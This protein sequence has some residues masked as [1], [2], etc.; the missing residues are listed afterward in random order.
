ML[1]CA[2]VTLSTLVILVPTLVSAADLDSGLAAYDRQ[3]FVEA[4]SVLQEYAD[5][6]NAR[7]QF[8]IG[9]MLA[10]GRGGD[11]DVPAGL[12]WL[13]S[14]AQNGFPL[15]REQAPRWLENMARLTGSERARAEAVIAA[16]GSEAV[17]TR[18]LPLL[19]AHGC[20]GYH[21][22][23]AAKVMSPSYPHSGQREVR[24]ASVLVRFIVGVD[25][26]P[27]APRI[28]ASFPEHA[29]FEEAAI[30]ALLSSRFWPAELGNT[31]VEAEADTKFLFDVIG[32]G[33]LWN[34][35]ALKTLQKEADAGV[36]SAQYL[37]ST[38]V[39]SDQRALGISREQALAYLG[40]A[41]QSG[42]VRAAAW[43]AE[44]LATAP[45]CPYAES[46]TQWAARAA[47]G[48]IPLAQVRYARLLLQG[49]PSPDS[50]AQARNYLVA[51]AEST[52]EFAAVHAI[53]MLAT[54][55]FDIMRDTDSLKSARKRL[56]I[57]TQ[58]EDPQAWE[59]L[60]AADADLGD[61][62]EAVANEEKAL[63]LAQQFL[64]KTTS[65]T[66]RLGSYRRR[67]AWRGDLFRLPPAESPVP[68]PAKVHICD[69]HSTG[70]SCIHEFQKPNWA[71]IEKQPGS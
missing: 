24:N 9:A 52:S 49:T 55:P 25:G 32:G 57:E 60:A 63:R 4:R 6:G 41:A 37:L 30:H 54:S 12:G 53:G 43:V 8:A 44:E 11:K 46:A 39:L 14:S 5:L 45:D 40:S 69:Q 7:A 51:A 36:V 16:R 62:S 58:A 19:R 1:F 29:G 33:F 27:R 64:W 3:D 23:A 48:G 31:P 13:L 47:R 26:L 34:S 68:L 66:E 17:N 15:A 35:A 56:K 20:A 21:P 50:V 70:T 61:F 42:D 38:V 71:S 22:V 10:Q 2:R 67:S 59:A 18:L 65:M 28:M